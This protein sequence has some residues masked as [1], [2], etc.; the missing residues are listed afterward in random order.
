MRPSFQSTMLM[1]RPIP[2]PAASAAACGFAFSAPGKVGVEMIACTNMPTIAI[3]QQ[4][5]VGMMNSSAS[6]KLAASSAATRNMY[7]T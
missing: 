2:P 1:T 6:I 4:I 7:S 3:V 5:S